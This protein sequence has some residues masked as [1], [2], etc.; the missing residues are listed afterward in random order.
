VLTG[1][2]VLTQRLSPL[3]L[4]KTRLVGFRILEGTSWRCRG[5]GSKKYKTRLLGFRVIK[6]NAFRVE[7]GYELEMQR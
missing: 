4:T 3:K 5:S 2:Q 6:T 1:F 7:G